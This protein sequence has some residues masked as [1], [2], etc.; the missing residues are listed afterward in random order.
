MSTTKKELYRSLKYFL[1]ALPLLFLA[2]VVVTMGFKAIKHQQNYLWLILGI[3][4]ATG[5]ILIAYMGIRTFLN[6]LF[7]KN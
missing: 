5:A 3:L 6:A 2:P 1:I 4:L 7:N